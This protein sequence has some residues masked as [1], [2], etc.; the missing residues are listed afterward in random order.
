MKRIAVLISKSTNNEI[1]IQAA[2]QMA[3][4]LQLEITLYHFVTAPQNWESLGRTV[5]DSHPQAKRDMNEARLVMDHLLMEIRAEKVAARKAYLLYDQE[6]RSTEN[7]HNVDTLVI[8]DRKMFEVDNTDILDFLCEFTPVKLIVGNEFKVKNIEDVVLSSDF[9]TLLPQCVS[10]VNN[11]I[12]TID[13]NL[14]LVFI[15]T[16]ETREN[17][18]I[19]IE[20][21]KRV[22]TQNGFRK[23][24]ISIFNSDCR[25]KGVED[26]AN[27][28]GGDLIITEEQC[29]VNLK[30]LNEMHLP[31]IIINK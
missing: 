13:F 20:N 10:L 24:S 31:I 11:L 7:T 9:H 30:S 25:L 18:K 1:I 6:E 22:I 3:Q 28:R 21:M 14:N 27:L 17:S 29:K 5:R 12:D 8:T 15:D 19:S 4:I 16:N 23:T 2:I 26:F